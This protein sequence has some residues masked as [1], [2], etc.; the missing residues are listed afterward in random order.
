MNKKNMTN[1][2][3]LSNLLS[4]MGTN[5]E[6]P[7]YDV[8]KLL[9]EAGFNPDEVGKRFQIVANQSMAKSPHNWRYRAHA[10]QL[11]AKEDYVKT[12]PMDKRNRSRAEILDAINSL[13]SQ[14]NLGVSFA[15]R[16]LSDQTDEDMESLLNQ[17][18][19]IVAHKSIDTDE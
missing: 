15:H 11:R 9:T 10:A 12:K 19:Y 17:I 6:E 18:E 3:Q 7:S 13:V 14:H 1:K 16:N 8:D 5:D 4:F 2:D